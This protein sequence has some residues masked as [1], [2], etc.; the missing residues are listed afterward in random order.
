MFPFSPSFLA[1]RGSSTSLHSGSSVGAPASAVDEP[2]P[3]L[4]LDKEPLTAIETKD[5]I[6]IPCGDKGENEISSSDAAVLVFPETSTMFVSGFCQL[7]LLRG[8]ASIN[9]FNLS[10]YKTVRNI[11][12]P[13]WSPALPLEAIVK[14][15]SQSSRQG[16]GVKQAILKALKKADK[17]AVLNSI[18]NSLNKE[19]DQR[20]TGCVVLVEGVREEDQQWMVAA[21]DKGAFN[22]NSFANSH[23]AHVGSA[24]V[25]SKVTLEESKSR[26]E[27]LFIPPSWREAV[28]KTSNLLEATPSARVLLCGAKG[29]GKSSCLRFATNQ[30]LKKSKVVCL[31]DCDVGQPE[32]G[33]PGTLSLHLVVD[34]I[35]SLPH[36]NLQ[37]PILS[38]Y[39]GD[40][41][42]KNDPNLLVE[43][44]THLLGKYNETRLA[45]AAGRGATIVE[46][47]V[48]C[49]TA[50]R[51]S[52]ARK[53]ALSAN[54]FEA[55]DTGDDDD[56][57]F[58]APLSLPLV[59][60]TDGYIRYMG[61]EILG[62][63]VDAVDPDRILHLMTDK[64]KHLPAL[65]RYLVEEKRGGGDGGMVYNDH[66]ETL[67]PGK[68]AP[69]PISAA[70]LRSLRMAAYFLGKDCSFLSDLMMTTNSGVGEGK[71]THYSDGKCT[72][73]GISAS[74]NSNSS[75]VV[76]IRSA[77][78]VDKYGT[79]ASALCA[80]PAY[81]IPLDQVTMQ[82]AGGGGAGAVKNDALPA[83]FNGSLVGILK[84]EDTKQRKRS[85]D[86]DEMNAS[87]SRC[88]GLG[89]VR[90]VDES[91]GKLLLITPTPVRSLPENV[92]LVMGPM[93]L[94]M[95]M[96]YSPLM[97]THPF[98]TSESAGDGS[99]K[100]KARNNVKRR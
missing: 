89:V 29:V 5:V 94:P 61:A 64:D 48:G 58:D 15:K 67:L 9:G 6:V 37:E 79:V 14:Q 83:V 2:G 34:P 92:L 87:P 27:P 52:K 44:V 51:K 95:S 28:H 46:G 82:C 33:V 53:V 36:L 70:D 62:A 90:H 19:T 80:M 20:L 39:Y 98:M 99:A 91:A 30:L 63:V 65:N 78:I 17:L 69:S 7:T 86:H 73:T 3:S 93:Q 18:Q 24:V 74:S 72:G 76:Q 59:V 49:S 56:G 55:L 12:A 45:F 22:C 68:L 77:A 75:A 60:N 21:E 71:D 57:N 8:Q 40:T 1:A 85:L 96:T 43:M 50:A 47:S 54:S 97:P 81:S 38:F 35:L 16:G 42:T 13:P 88:V 11:C 66:V 31:L 4:S 84:V 26:I 32:L 100:M 41:T 23:V 25:A 10:T